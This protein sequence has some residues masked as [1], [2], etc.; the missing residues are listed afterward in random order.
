[1]GINE[2]VSDLKKLGESSP[3]AKIISKELAQRERMRHETDTNRFKT[4]LK[5]KGL[6]VDDKEFD[7]YWKEAGKLEVG[8]LDKKG[9]F[10]WHFNLKSVGQIGLGQQPEE[11]LEKLENKKSPVVRRPRGRPA[12]A[13]SKVEQVGYFFRNKIMLLP[14]DMS[15]SEADRL[16]EFIR[17]IP[18][19]Q[20]GA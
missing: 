18:Q 2:L 11:S 6:K 1:M 3:T 15:S 20:S 8:S 9:R 16:A 10:R 7:T 14:M 4:Y 17:T 12:T 13:T 19:L 5:N